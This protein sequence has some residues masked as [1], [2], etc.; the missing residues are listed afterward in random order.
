MQQFVTHKYIKTNPA[1]RQK[2]IFMHKYLKK[3]FQSTIIPIFWKAQKL[4]RTEE[5]KEITM[6]W[7]EMCR[8]CQNLERNPREK[9]TTWH[10]KSIK[11]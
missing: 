10:E 5:N 11:M 3:I 9:H 1:H 4:K 6:E 7:E 8:E 2:R